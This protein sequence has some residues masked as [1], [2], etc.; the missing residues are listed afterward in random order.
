MDSFEKNDGRIRMGVVL[1]EEAGKL[2][3]DQW[4]EELPCYTPPG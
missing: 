1:K 3:R 4:K 2:K